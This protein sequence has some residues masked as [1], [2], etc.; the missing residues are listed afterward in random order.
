[1]TYPTAGER[2]KAFRLDVTAAVDIT[3]KQANLLL[4]TEHF[5]QLQQ[6]SLL[7]ELNSAEQAL[8]AYVE[9][10]KELAAR[11]AV[12]I[13]RQ[14]INVLANLSYAQSLADQSL[15][16]QV[17]NI[18]EYGCTLT[19]AKNFAV[20][21]RVALALIFYPNVLTLF[22]FATVV[23]KTATRSGTQLHLQFDDLGEKQTQSLR[24][25]LFQLQT[26]AKNRP[27]A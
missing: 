19:T 10:I 1:M 5:Q 9:R 23:T 22:C 27:P 6:L 2:R 8:N 12:A 20:E 4:A 15:P 25:H 3:A 13:L 17:I 18:S 26:A 14:Q 21:D 7:Q 24:K 11:K 16:Q